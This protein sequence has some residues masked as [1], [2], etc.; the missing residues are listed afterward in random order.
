MQEP[1]TWNSLDSLLDVS[2]GAVW[3]D[4]I[5]QEAE[6]GCSP[7][8]MTKTTALPTSGHH[9]LYHSIY[10]VSGI[11]WPAEPPDGIVDRKMAVP[12]HKTSPDDPRTVLETGDAALNKLHSQMGVAKLQTTHIGTETCFTKPRTMV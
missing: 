3:P 5:E 10:L 1:Q 8:Q 2:R 4:R 11:F 9:H 7:R 6:V 12:I